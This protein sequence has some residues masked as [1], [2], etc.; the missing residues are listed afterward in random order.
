MLDD[1]EMIELMIL[2]LTVKGK[3]AKQEWIIKAVELAKKIP[4]S[5]CSLS[6]LSGILT[7]TDKVIDQAYSQKVKEVMMLTKV[8]R[9]FYEDGLADG[10][11]EGKTNAERM[12]SNLMLSLLSEQRY[13][14]IEA[15]SKDPNYR[16][17]LY[18]E[19][20]IQALE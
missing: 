17:E 13:S 12:F 6:V 16:E 10:R 14:D 9:L 8:E 20:G 18:Q 1:E 19:Y 5:S 4:V 15:A 3:E 7:F 2:P 11:N